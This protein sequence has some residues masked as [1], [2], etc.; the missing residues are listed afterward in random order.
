VNDPALRGPAGAPP[1]ARAAVALSVALLLA[2]ALARAVLPPVTDSF[3][4]SKRLHLERVLGAYPWRHAAEITAIAFSTDGELLA[5][6]GG[7]R[8]IKLWRA[9]GEELR[10]L[11]P[12]KG[13]TYDLGFAPDGRTLFSTSSLGTVALWDVATGAQRLLL[14][15]GGAVVAAAFNPDG[16]RLVSVGR[17]RLVRIWDATTGAPIASASFAPQGDAGPAAAFVAVAATDRL[18]LVAFAD[19]G[20]V[21]IDLATGAPRAA[22]THALDIDAA[23]FSGDRRRLVAAAGGYLHVVDLASGA[24][25]VAAANLGAVADVAVSAHGDKV[26]VA[27]RDGRL[28]AWDID[29]GALLLDRMAHSAE[30]AGVALSPSGALGATASRDYS[31]RLWDVGAGAPKPQPIGRPLYAV[32]FADA[33]HVVTG[34]ADGQVRVWDLRAQTATIVGQHTGAIYALAAL[35]PTT[36]VSGGDDG[37]LRFWSLAG[38]AVAAVKAHPGGVLA[39]AA[40]PDGKRLVSAGADERVRQWDPRRHRAVGELAMSAPAAAVALAADGRHG[41][42]GDDSGLLR[43]FLVPGLAGA[44][45]AHLH[46]GLILGARFAPDGKRLVTASEDGTARLWTALAR[47]ERALQ[48]HKGPVT[49]AVFTAD[50]RAAISGAK[51]GTIVVWDVAT[52]APLDRLDL[53]ASSDQPL[54]LALSPDGTRLAVATARGVVLVFRLE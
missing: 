51:D 18:A 2:P 8:R 40:S 28:S 7:D 34:G 52:G 50:G 21:E 3:R 44:G 1:R 32:A 5:T 13:G 22:V 9:G 54:A 4:D 41:A 26:L 25:R 31:F 45:R 42:A 16:R 20:V 48:G 39:L 37:T 36:V 49:C 19:G 12:V 17:D 38:G 46:A 10:S 23:A 6:A 14:K 47:P 11:G 35:G 33:D 15:H 27:G 29:R 43:A 24:D 53:G 30:I